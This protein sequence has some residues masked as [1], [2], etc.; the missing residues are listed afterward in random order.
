ML[1]A[2][3]I[4]LTFEEEDKVGGQKTWVLVTHAET[5]R[6]KLV[7]TLAKKWKELFKLDL[8]IINSDN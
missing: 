2:N 3:G 4:C 8:P 7:Q 6:K 1:S 5:E